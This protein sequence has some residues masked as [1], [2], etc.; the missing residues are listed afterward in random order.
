MG[1]SVSTLFI[2]VYF[3]HEIITILSNMMC[4]KR[5]WKNLLNCESEEGIDSS[6]WSSPKYAAIG[7]H[8]QNFPDQR[9]IK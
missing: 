4:N 2:Y 1:Q 5:T 3:F 9:D 8:L 7:E 6:V